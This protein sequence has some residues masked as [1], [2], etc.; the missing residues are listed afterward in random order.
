MATIKSFG[1]KFQIDDPA[2]SGSFTSVAALQSIGDW[3]MS[4][5]TQD[6]TTHN[7]ALVS[8][9]QFRERVVTLLDAGTIPLT[10]LFDPSDGTHNHTTDGLIAMFVAKQARA[11][12]VV[13]PSSPEV[14][15]SFTGLVTNVGVN[16]GNVDDVLSMSATV[17]LSGAVTFA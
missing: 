13:F 9:G 17:Q 12:R 14:T 4:G 3:S 8:G 15:W 2:G 11:C 7:A 1:V 5:E 10:V 16:A 6:V